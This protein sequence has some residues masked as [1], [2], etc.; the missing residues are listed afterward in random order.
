MRGGIGSRLFAAVYD[1]ATGSM[2]R[3]GLA[4]W[5]AELLEGVRGRVLEVGAGTGANLAAYPQGLERLVT[6]RRRRALR[7]RY[8]EMTRSV[9]NVKS[10]E[11][12]AAA[13]Q[14]D[15]V[16][17]A[18]FLSLHP[19]TVLPVTVRLYGAPAP[20]AGIAGST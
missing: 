15:S 5:R 10:L 14:V 3:A 7:A 18:P 17:L 9:A 13:R 8:L 2:E 1:R 12:A 16:T 4:A 19:V 6:R 11:Y 20:A